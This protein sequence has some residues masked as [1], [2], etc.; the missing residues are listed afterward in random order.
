MRRVAAADRVVAPLALFVSAYLAT[1]IVGLSVA[2]VTG[3]HAAQ[4]VALLAV[5]VATWAAVMLNDRGKWPLG[6]AVAPRAAAREALFGCLF[7]ALLIIAIDRCI[8]LTA[9]V[10]HGA[11]I[12]FPWLELGAVYLP[13]VFH[14][15]LLFRGYAYQRLRNRNRAVAIVL[16]SLLFAGVHAGNAAVSWLALT[17]IAVAG[18]LLALAYERY[19]RLWFPIGI[20]FGWNIVSG[21]ILGYGVSGYASEATVLT[22]QVRGAAW[23]TG[24]AF[25]VEGSVCALAVEM[26]AVVVLA[27]T[28]RSHE[29]RVAE[30]R[31]QHEA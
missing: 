16:T 2:H 13:A 1:L 4:W 3:F 31:L 28:V 12:G 17:N 9:F 15:E 5:V 11:G 14:E 10:R 21:S 22:T 30:G 18:V 7:A 20:H 8:A 19:R 29:R 26:V 6:L 23:L 24:G 27:I 25:G